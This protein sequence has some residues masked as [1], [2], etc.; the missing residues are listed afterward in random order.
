MLLIF[1]ILYPVF[2]QKIVF[3]LHTFIQKKGCET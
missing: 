3:F 2:D 1:K